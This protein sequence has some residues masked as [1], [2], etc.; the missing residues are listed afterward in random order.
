MKVYRDVEIDRSFKRVLK[1]IGKGSLFGVSDRARE[2]R[3]AA[4]Q[5]KTFTKGEEGMFGCLI[6]EGDR[7]RSKAECG[8]RSMAGDGMGMGK[9]MYGL[10]WVGRRR[11]TIQ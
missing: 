2:R 1:G 10:G 11:K 8:A 4:K 9:G 3:A 7:R 5:R 6:H